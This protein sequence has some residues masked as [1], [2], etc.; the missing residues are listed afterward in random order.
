[1]P[2]SMGMMGAA[3]LPQGSSS[4]P[5]VDRTTWEH[6]SANSLVD[7]TVTRAGPGLFQGGAPALLCRGDPPCCGE[8]GHQRVW[9][10]GECRLRTLVA[11]VEAVREAGGET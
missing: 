6:R 8:E 10:C 5:V 4:P 3:P 2:S 7:G 1:M 11:Q 9:Q